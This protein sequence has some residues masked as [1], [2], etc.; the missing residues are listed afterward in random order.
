[1]PLSDSELKG[2]KA[3][4]KR[5]VVS[6]GNS[7]FAVVE[8]VGEGGRKSIIGSTS[9]PPCRSSQQVEARIDLHSRV[10]VSRT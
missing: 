8:S 3:G 9:F 2:L 1:M 6:V 5:K 4:T 10:L 7:V